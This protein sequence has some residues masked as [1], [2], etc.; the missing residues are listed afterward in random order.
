MVPVIKIGREHSPLC[1]VSLIRL[2]TYLLYCLL[3]VP[4]SG[5]SAVTAVYTSDT[6]L[7]AIAKIQLGDANLWPLMLEASDVD[8]VAGLVIGQILII[9]VA[10]VEAAH[11]AIADALTNIQN[12][13][14]MGAQLFAYVEISEAI[15][16]RDSALIQLKLGDWDDAI[17][18]ATKAKTLASQALGISRRNRQ[19]AAEARLSD[20]H[21]SVEGQRPG[22]PGWESRALN[23]VLIE[24]EK[25]RTLSDSTA[26][27]TFRDAGRLRL[28]ANSHAVIQRM[29]V[30]PL[31]KR[32]DAKVILVEGDFYAL[33]GSGSSR[34]N[35]E[36]ELPG[37]HSTIESGNFWVQN[38]TSG[39]KF[40]NYDDEP[41]RITSLGATTDLGR[42][43]GVVIRTGKGVASKVALLEAP[44]LVAPANRSHVFNTD[45]SLLWNTVEHASAYWL[46][47]A[48][49]T[50]FNTVVL[51]LS[52]LPQS[53]HTVP[54]IGSGTY[55][56][57]VSAIDQFG[58]PGQRSQV[59][60]FN[61]RVDNSAPYLRIFSPI[62]GTIFRNAEVEI[63]GETE[64]GALVLVNDKTVKTTNDGRFITI[65]SAVEGI[66]QLLLIARDL[67][68]NET[69]VSR[70]FTHIPDSEMAIVFSNNLRRIS[71]V[72]FLTNNS[73]ISLTGNTIS[74][75]R[76]EVSDRMNILRVVAKSKSDGSFSFT[77][78]VQNTTEPFTIKTIAASGFETSSSFQVT[79]DNTPPAI[80]LDVPLPRLTSIE[81]LQLRGI[82][83][84]SS[85]VQLNKRDILLS[86]GSFEEDLIL[87]SGENDIEIIARDTA[88]NVTVRRWTIILD[89]QSPT[90][91]SHKITSKVRGKIVIEVFAEDN[92][93]LAKAAPFSL[94]IR[95]HIHKGFLRYN[96]MS[97]SYKGS[98]SVNTSPGEPFSLSTVKL[99]DNAGN[100]IL[101]KLQ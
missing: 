96:K 50:D 3:C 70:D 63:V 35:L 46:E 18:K 33:L 77:L 32:E 67:A 99:G 44:I 80:T 9:P 7:R 87:K 24:E 31:N 64:P 69:S 15:A 95:E 88:G 68:G 97:G 94:R 21:G 37:V 51:S 55:Y 66:N 86:D 27:I 5:M 12:A 14:T 49:D 54:K 91:I 79:V 23:A 73:T 39:A 11:S 98:V 13:N 59:Y 45:A 61:I 53:A 76:L 16:L 19:R 71:D 78:P 84:D 26:Q 65:V 100:Q 75:A 47:I 90:Y 29:R 34:N 83:N 93:G 42:N 43:E 8:N 28:S 20:R 82:I 62:A 101:I 48:Q 60:H 6:D 72:H 85:S 57:R 92:S 2:L 10:A 40:T 41:V 4:V 52:K 1:H 89:K 81:W 22:E 74:N 36:V 30:D 38:D 17:V 56:W 25:I 58:L